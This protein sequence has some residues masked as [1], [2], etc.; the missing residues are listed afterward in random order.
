MRRT[1]LPLFLIPLTFPLSLVYGF[2]TALRNF[3]FNKRIFRATHFDIPVIGIGNLS[4]GG[5]GKTPTTE[6]LV[7][8]LSTQGHTPAILSRGYGRRTKGFLIA[9]DGATA[10]TIGDEPLQMFTN[11]KTIPV[12]V[13]E[14]RVEGIIQLIKNKEETSVVV[15]DDCYQ[16]RDLHCSAYVLCSAY[17][18]PF[19][20]D[21][22][23]PLGYLREYRH[24]ARR[25]TIVMVTK[26]PEG[27]SDSERDTIKQKIGKYTDAPVFFSG[28]AY[29]AP[30][31]V[32]GTA[33]PLPKCLT[34]LTAIA[35]PEGFIAHL[36]TLGTVNEHIRKGDHYYFATSELE[37]L[38]HKLPE[39]TAL[40]TTQKDYMRLKG[41]IDHWDK[42]VYY[43][44]I[45]SVL[46]GAEA[47]EVIRLLI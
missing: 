20:E 40:V 28:Y 18:T 14:S 42:P 16:H 19:Y 46:I 10:K 39:N 37:T 11:L 41:R 5:S 25:A 9:D 6:W 38:Y 26:C 23:L 30:V 1:P 36:R 35:H 22:M 31:Q 8:Q 29:S 34:A 44:P 24:N 43:V 12:A 17:D 4:A 47:N 45:R 2:I 13:C 27:I 21:H 32:C 15:L 7:S 33:Q 3:L